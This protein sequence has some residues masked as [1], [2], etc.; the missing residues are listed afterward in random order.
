MTPTA[1]QAGDRYGS[2]VAV[3]VFASPPTVVVWRCDSC[4]AEGSCGTTDFRGR[5]C[6]GCVGR[7][8]GKLE[9]HGLSKTPEYCVWRGMLS[10]CYLRSHSS[11][12][13]YGARGI[14]VCD[15]WRSPGGFER[16]LAHIG[17]RPTA[18]HSVDRF[19]NPSGN[20]EPGNVRWATV[21][22]QAANHPAGFMQKAIARR[23]QTRVRNRTLCAWDRRHTLY[24][25][26][27]TSRLMDDVR[28]ALEC[29]FG[30]TRNEVRIEDFVVEQSYWD[31][32]YSVVESIGMCEFL[33]ELRTK[34][35]SGPKR[36]MPLRIEKLR[37]RG[38][39]KRAPRVK[40][41]KRG[42]RRGRHCSFCGKAGHGKATCP[43][44]RAGCSPFADATAAE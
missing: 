15:E 21:A 25:A 8:L 24:W 12:C 40:S 17:F 3:H 18:G 37:A 23:K 30:S 31:S 22:E 10:R 29:E 33:D 16:F 44:E 26:S 42:P 35:P 36:G 13:A 41:K 43:I 11:F 34:L 6:R 5:R 20:Y 1:L 39:T 32:D 4:G 7:A 2:R 9:T 28:S 38:I 27:E 14:R 19:P